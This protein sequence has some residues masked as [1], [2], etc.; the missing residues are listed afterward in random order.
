LAVRLSQGTKAETPVIR[1][2]WP[3]LT[4]LTLL[5]GVVGPVALVLAL[6]RLPAATS[7]LLLNLEAGFTLVIAVL[8]G[9][10]H[11]GRRGDGC[12]AKRSWPV[13]SPQVHAV[14]PSAP[15]VQGRWPVLTQIVQ[16]TSLQGRCTLP[17]GLRS[18]LPAG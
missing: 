14:E 8:L 12:R 11:L 16:P 4:V 10:E 7:S 3:A 6:A 1:Q 17:G 9:R 13:W 18:Q 5:G 2:D 15:T